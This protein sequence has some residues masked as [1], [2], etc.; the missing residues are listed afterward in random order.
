MVDQEIAPRDD[1][2]EVLDTVQPGLRHRGPGI[3]LQLWA[4]EL[5]EGPERRGIEESL[6]DVHLVGLEPELARQER[7]NLIGGGTVQLEPDRRRTSESAPQNGLDRFEEIPSFLLLQLE[8][9]VSGETERRVADDLHAGEEDLQVR[10]DDLLDRDEPLAIRHLD[11]PRQ[12]WRDLHAGE[13]PLSARGVT[14]EGREVER[15]GGDVG[16]RVRGVD[17]QRGQYREDPLD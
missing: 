14:N 15:E 17:G 4:V 9:R 7:S 3:V 12:Q 11:E 10:G 16:E 2:E 1:V 5:I 6:H 8:V 13:T